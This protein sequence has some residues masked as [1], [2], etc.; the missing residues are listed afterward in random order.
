MQDS[1]YFAYFPPYPY[2]RHQELVARVHV[3]K[4][5]SLEIL[6]PALDGNDLDLLRIGVLSLMH[7]VTSPHVTSPHVS[8]VVSRAFYNTSRE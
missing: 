4:G 6:G 5:V 8:K 2:T 1:I 3:K 7:F